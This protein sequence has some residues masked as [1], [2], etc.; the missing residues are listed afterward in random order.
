MD[1]WNVTSDY[2]ISSNYKN[3][4]REESVLAISGFPLVIKSLEKCLSFTYSNSRPLQVLK[5]DNGA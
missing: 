3:Y 2:N 5:N 4:W 1:I